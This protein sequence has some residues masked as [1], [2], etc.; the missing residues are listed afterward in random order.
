VASLGLSIPTANVEP[1][2]TVHYALYFATLVTLTYLTHLNHYTSRQAS[3]LILLFYPIYALIALVRF[4][5]MLETGR[6]SKSTDTLVLAR[7]S[8]WLISVTAGMIAFCLELFSPEK[9][10]R[11]WTWKRSGKIA[12]DED[13]EEERD[14]VDSLNGGGDV[15]GKN[16]DGDME[17]PVLTANIYERLTFSWLTRK[18]P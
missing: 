12:L 18:Y 1:L 7:E 6:L 2:A 10:F 4:R 11:K 5:T 3:T 13:E 15:P 17:S 9:R 14:G 8:L 16:E